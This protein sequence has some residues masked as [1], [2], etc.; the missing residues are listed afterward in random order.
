MPSPGQLVRVAQSTVLSGF[1]L[2]GATSAAHALPPE[3]PHK[4]PGADLFST[5][6]VQILR[7]TIA[8]GD[9][10]RLRREPR[11]FVPAA[12]QE[13][14]SRYTEVAV[15]LK[16]SVGSFRPID[17]KPGFTLDFSTYRA[18]QKFHGLRRIHLNNSVEDP[19]YCNELLGSEL[20]RSAGIPAPRVNRAL[21]FLNDR[22]LGLY[23]LK[24]GFTEDFLSCYFSH[25]GGNLF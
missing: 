7:L 23:V 21:V 20:F 14:D 22:R 8:D 5:D 19:A 2:L 1:V 17:D 16:G 12:V 15:H 24:E 13:S 6:Q 11:Q 25:I 10:D 18:G 4:W 9:L 3:D